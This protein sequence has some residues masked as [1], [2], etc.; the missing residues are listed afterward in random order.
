MPVEGWLSDVTRKIFASP[1]EKPDSVPEQRVSDLQI[2]PERSYRLWATNGLFVWYVDYSGFLEQLP[3]PPTWAMWSQA[4]IN[5]TQTAFRL[6]DGLVLPT[7]NVPTLPKSIKKLREG[8]NRPYYYRPLYDPGVT[9]N[10]D[11]GLEFGLNAAQLSH[12]HSEYAA[13]IPLINLRLLDLASCFRDYLAIEFMLTRCQLDDIRGSDARQ[14]F[15]RYL[16]DPLPSNML[17]PRYATRLTLIQAGGLGIIE[18]EWL[19]RS[20]IKVMED[21]PVRKKVRGL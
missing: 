7:P 11:T 3:E 10:S 9:G 16:R 17:R 15:Q 12:L 1:P 4:C 13:E 5:Q 14:A 20:E 8:G 2:V 19:N 18:K 21:D 6:P